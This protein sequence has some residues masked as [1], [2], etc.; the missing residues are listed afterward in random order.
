MEFLKSFESGLRL[1]SKWPVD[2]RL[3]TCYRRRQKQGFTKEMSQFGLN[4]KYQQFE[5]NISN[6][7]CA[8]SPGLDS[9]NP[10]YNKSQR[11]LFLDPPSDWP[12][13]Q[14]RGQFKISRL[15]LRQ[16]AAA[17]HYKR[18][19]SY[20]ILLATACCLLQLSAADYYYIMQP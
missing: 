1:E 15:L 2:N 5:K 14:S 16:L 18:K 7:F 17:A 8:S 4:K 3:K 13:T 11:N 19:T 6:I 10:W 12:L 20:C 9:T